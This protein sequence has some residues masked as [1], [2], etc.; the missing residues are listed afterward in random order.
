[1]IDLLQGNLSKFHDEN[2][3]WV[4]LIAEKVLLSFDFPW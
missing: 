4:K 2:V 1:M 3:S